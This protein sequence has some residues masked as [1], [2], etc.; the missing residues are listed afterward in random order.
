MHRRT[1]LLAVLASPAAA[2]GATAPKVVATFSVLGDMVKRIAG[3]R[4]AL[5]VLV[6]IDDDIKTYEPTAADVRA[7]ADADLLVVNGLN[8]GFEP[9][10][11]GLLRQAQFHGVKLVASDGVR[12][13]KEADVPGATDAAVA[14]DLDPHA[15]LDAA[16]AAVYAANIQAAL[17]RL[18]PAQADA[19]RASGEAYR[20]EL[21]ELDRWAKQRISEVP[22]A[23]RTVITDDGFAY[24]GR[25][26]GI[27]TDRCRAGR[28]ALFGIAVQAGPEP[29]R[30]DLRGHVP[31]RYRDAVSRHDEKLTGC[32]SALHCA[33][34]RDRPSEIQRRPSAGAA[35][36][37]H[38]RPTPPCAVSR[39][40]TA[41]PAIQPHP[42]LVRPRLTG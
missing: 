8:P 38:P 7:V 40:G 31:P 2:Y 28:R 22:E 33:A 29:G 19:Y 10:L 34:H 27:R 39:S 41:Q 5:T 36:G 25:A 14:D 13:L 30:G 6:G 16:N 12:V 15:W 24:L 23:K 35:A 9:W 11:D 1:L 18:D 17:I 4:V 20:A 26:Y 32:S 21:L 3:D 42:G 37:T